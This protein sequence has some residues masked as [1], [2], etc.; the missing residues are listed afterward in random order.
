MI[1]LA[2]CAIKALLKEP[3]VSNSYQRKCLEVELVALSVLYLPEQASQLTAIYS[4]AFL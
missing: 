1:L 4:T 3:E 2:Q